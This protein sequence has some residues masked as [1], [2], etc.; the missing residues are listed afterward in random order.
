MIKFSELQQILFWGSADVWIEKGGAQFEQY[1]YNET[2]SFVCHPVQLIFSPVL[3][4]CYANLNKTLGK[5]TKNL[6]LFFFYCII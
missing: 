6:Y 3:E 1:Q 4:C 2:I 5:L